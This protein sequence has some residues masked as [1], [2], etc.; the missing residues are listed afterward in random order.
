MFRLEDTDVQVLS[1][2]RQHILADGGAILFVERRGVGIVG[3]CA[4]RHTGQGHFELTKMGVLESARGLKAGEALLAAANWAAHESKSG[5]KLSMRSRVRRAAGPAM[6]IVPMGNW[7][8]KP[9][10]AAMAFKPGV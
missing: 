5:A 3:A 4:L 10:G 8:L 7:P 9:T 6:L 1:Q 2:P